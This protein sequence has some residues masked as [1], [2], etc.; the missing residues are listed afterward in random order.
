MFSELTDEGQYYI[1]S[2]PAIDS[3]FS[4][5]EFISN[6]SVLTQFEAEIITLIFYYGY[7]V[8]E[9]AKSRNVSR[10]AINQAKKRAIKKLKER[11]YKL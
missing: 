1:Q 5:I 3:Q 9:I 4:E 8:S 7:K 11:Q 10:Q 6:L 2:T